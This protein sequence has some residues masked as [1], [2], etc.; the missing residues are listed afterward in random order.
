LE[1]PKYGEGKDLRGISKILINKI[2]NMKKRTILTLAALSVTCASFAQQTNAEQSKID[3]IKNDPTTYRNNGGLIDSD[4]LLIQPEKNERIVDPNGKFIIYKSSEEKEPEELKQ[5]HLK[6]N[7]NSEE[8]RLLKEN[9]LR[10]NP[11]SNQ[12]IEEVTPK[13]VEERN[14]IYKK[15]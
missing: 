9:Y 1:K 6:K 15:K 3:R 2:N 10:D 14:K 12:P 5:L 11:V 8:Y 13:S 4:Q 7:Q